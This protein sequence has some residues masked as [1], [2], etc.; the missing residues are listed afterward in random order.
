M[1]VVVRSVLTTLFFRFFFSTVS[2]AGERGQRGLS[3]EK[4]TGKY[5]GDRPGKKKSDENKVLSVDL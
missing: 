5:E 2:L 1:F 4:K 3:L